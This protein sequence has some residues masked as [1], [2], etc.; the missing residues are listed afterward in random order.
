MKKRIEIG[1]TYW[2]ARS[3]E[4]ECNEAE[5]WILEEYLQQEFG[6]KVLFLKTEKAVDDGVEERGNLE[7]KKTRILQ[8]KDVI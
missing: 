2:V 4:W 1:R 3:N 6:S 5:T 7:S 8:G